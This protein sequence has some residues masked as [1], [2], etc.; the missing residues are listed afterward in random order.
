[1]QHVECTRGESED[2]EIQGPKVPEHF[3]EPCKIQDGHLFG[4]ISVLLLVLLV[5]MDGGW[6]AKMKINGRYQEF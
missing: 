5:L 3:Q 4:I 2:A 1:M 6:H